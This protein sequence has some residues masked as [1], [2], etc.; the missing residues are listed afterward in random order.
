M[1]DSVTYDA[2]IIGGGPAG[3]SAALYTARERMK[4]LVLDKG[5]FGG[6][7]AVTETIDNYPGFKDGIGGRALIDEMVGQV[8]RFGAVCES[9]AT[10]TSIDSSG[11]EMRVLTEEEGKSYKAKTVLLTTGST[12]RKLHVPGEDD[13]IGRGI[14]FCATCDAPLYKGKQVTVIGGGNSALQESLFIARFASHIDLFVKDAA[15]TGSEVLQEA[16]Q[17][18]AN[19]AVHYNVETQR[20]EKPEAHGPITIQ[21]QTN[22]APKTFETDGIFVFIGLLPNSHGFDECGIDA[23]GFIQSDEL[24]QTKTPGVFVAGD[25]RSGSTWQIGAAVGEGISAALAMR[26]YLDEHFPGW[27]KK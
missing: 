11:K 18:E 23:R 8:E 4:T 13:L 12:Y 15:L 24:F 3:L 14:H 6:M 1:S 5:S 16:I 22:H 27:H 17:A 7:A 25:V 19:I 2:V 26:Q 9:F 20:I 21:T 10:V